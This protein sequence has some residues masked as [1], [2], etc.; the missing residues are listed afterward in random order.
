VVLKEKLSF[1]SQELICPNYLMIVKL[2]WNGRSDNIATHQK[3]FIPWFL[4]ELSPIRDSLVNIPVVWIRNSIFPD[5][6]CNMWCHCLTSLFPCFVFAIE[7]FA[8]L[9]CWCI[10]CCLFVH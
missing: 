9:F 4:E 10:P 3:I 2:V 5:D 7:T 8:V 1:P 6:Q